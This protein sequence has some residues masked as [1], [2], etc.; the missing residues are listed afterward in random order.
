MTP[1][2]LRC[3]ADVGRES[4][5]DFANLGNTNV[6]YFV[7]LD[8]SRDT[9]DMLL[10]GDRNITGGTLA[11]PN[12]LVVRTNNPLSWTKSIHISRGNVGLADGSVSQV[13]GPRLNQQVAAM[14]NAAIRLAIP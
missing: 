6:S 1:K 14:T 3:P 7:G 2:L 10:S 9:Q 5:L 11:N 4:A 13:D 8:A 12:L